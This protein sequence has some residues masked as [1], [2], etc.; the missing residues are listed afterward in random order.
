MMTIIET[1]NHDNN[2]WSTQPRWQLL[3][4]PT[5]M[6]LIGITISGRPQLSKPSEFLEI[7]WVSHSII[8]QIIQCQ[9][10]GVLTQE[11]EFYRV[12]VCV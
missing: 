1:P 4:Y 10:G 3:K 6:G 2:Y 5:K 11:F 9:G 12:P 7:D 8:F